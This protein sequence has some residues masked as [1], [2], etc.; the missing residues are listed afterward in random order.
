M[1]ILDAAKTKYQFNSLFSRKIWVSQH[2]KGKTF[3]DFNKTRDDRVA[4]A[5]YANHMHLAA[6]R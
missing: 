5:S 6:D 3:L 4:V 1:C 2:Q